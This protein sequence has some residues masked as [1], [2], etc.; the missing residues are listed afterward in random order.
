MSS[1]RQLL[2]VT[3]GGDGDSENAGVKR[4]Q[5]GYDDAD[6]YY[7][8]LLRQHGGNAFTPLDTLSLPI[9]ANLA[10]EKSCFEESTVCA[11]TCPRN[12]EEAMI[13]A[14]SSAQA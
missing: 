3:S 11:H 4:N 9:V 7:D 1:G 10:A 6:D 8:F 12:I 13:I 14:K 5:Q 2:K